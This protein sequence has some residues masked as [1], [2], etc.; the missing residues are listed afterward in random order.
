VKEFWASLNAGQRRLTVIG[1]SVLFILLNWVFVWPHFWDWSRL[2]GEL[3]TASKTVATRQAMIAQLDALKRQEEKLRAEG[4]E[5]PSDEQSYQFARAIQGQAGMSGVRIVTQGSTR[6]VSSTN[7]F[8]AEKSQ[9]ITVQ[10]D[11]K[12]LVD[13]LYGLGTSNSLVRVRALSVSP[14]PPHQT[15]NSQ[16][17][18]VASY[19]KDLSKAPPPAAKPAAAAPKPTETKPPAAVAK[20]PAPVTKPT[21]PVTGARPTNA[22]PPGV[23]PVAPPDNRPSVPPRPPMPKK[24]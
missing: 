9:I 5:V 15:L 20:P 19:Q 12:Q 11:E 14:D 6:E 24:P 8:F 16:V 13:F 21:V 23:K 17:T 7:Q 4:A 10:S 1:L 18:L 3:D 22:P 2:Q